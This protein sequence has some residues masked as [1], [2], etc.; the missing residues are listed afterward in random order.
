MFLTFKIKNIVKLN[1]KIN[2]TNMLFYKYTYFSVV[3]KRH[4]TTKWLTSYFIQ[5]CSFSQVTL[6][7]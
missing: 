6:L 7:Y 4:A 3:F 5:H 1:F 2:G